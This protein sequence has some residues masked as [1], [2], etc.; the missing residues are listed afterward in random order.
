MYRQRRYTEFNVYFTLNAPGL[1]N[2]LDS[3]GRSDGLC[4]SMLVLEANDLLER[5]VAS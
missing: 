1:G 2:I 4:E 5:N 3:A